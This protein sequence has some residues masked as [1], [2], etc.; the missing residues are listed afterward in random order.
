MEQQTEEMEMLDL[1]PR[2]VFCVR[3]GMITRLNQPAKKLFLREGMP[4]APLLKAGSEDYAAFSGGM[5]YLTLVLH[6]RDFGASVMRGEQ[7]DVFTLDQQF[8]SEELRVLALAARELRT[9]LTGA[10][11]AAKK[12]PSGGAS[13]QLNRSLYQL[14]RIIGNMSDASGMSPAFQPEVQN[15]S[16]VFR[17]I[18]DK[19]IQLSDATGIHISY[20]GPDAEYAC[21][22]DRQL[23]ER[24]VLNMISNALK[25]T[26]KGGQIQL[27]LR[28]NG[29][30]FRFSVTD[31][32]RG[33][34]QKEQASIFSRYLREPAIED[35]RDG[36]GLG[37]PLIRLAA[38]RHLGAVL[39][40]RPEGFGTRV[41]VTFFSVPESN[42]GLHAAL[43]GS[44]YAGEQDHALI[45]LSEFLPPELY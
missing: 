35:T 36:I 26:P 3:D 10:M 44:D 7:E 30:Q 12:I 40:D 23:M 45:E 6:Q 33:I 24:A 2:P 13:G 22:M 11:L 25:Y 21:C 34:P 17:E 1:I 42:K 14:L 38:S 29:K 9:P 8:E 16:A 39:V 5:L 43:L 20:T 37:M 31:T 28:Q 18:A 27:V 41:T 4:L 32:G 19:A 15:V